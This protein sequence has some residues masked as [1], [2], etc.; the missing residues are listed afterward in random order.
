MSKRNQ[1]GME[2]LTNESL[3]MID[4]FNLVM[5]EVKSIYLLGKAS[6]KKATFLGGPKLKVTLFQ[7]SYSPKINVYLLMSFWGSVSP[8]ETS[9]MTS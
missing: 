6:L 3:E 2:I 5:I 8:S 9:L 1:F 4:S 7:Q